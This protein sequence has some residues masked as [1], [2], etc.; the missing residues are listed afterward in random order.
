MPEKWYLQTEDGTVLGPYHE[1]QIRQDLLSGNVA[2]S[3]RVRQGEGDWRDA[4]TARTIFERLLE[5]GW[6]VRSENVE[7][8]PFTDQRLLQL[9]T[10]GQISDSDEVRQSKLGVWKRAGGMLSR[11]QRYDDGHS[12][13]SP[14]SHQTPVESAQVTPVT[15]SLHDSSK[16]SAQRDDVASSSSEVPPRKWSTEPLRSFSCRLMETH[17]MN[18]DGTSRQ[19]NVR[20]SRFRERLLLTE[21]ADETTGAETLNLMRTNG[22]VVGCLPAQAARTIRANLELG[23]SHIVLV[24]SIGCHPQTRLWTMDLEIVVVPAGTPPVEAQ[25]FLHSL[26]LGDAP[27][28]QPGQ[29]TN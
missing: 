21:G 27:T 15:D 20:Q 6:Y 4:A 24:K 26:L 28:I 9:Y 11:W 23:C 2:P 16:K 1:A 3:S 14:T 22:Q 25:K 7:Y 5:V 18:P 13:S 10:E 8:G 12:R 29:P 17:R 19:M